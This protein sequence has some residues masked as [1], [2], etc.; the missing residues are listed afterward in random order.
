VPFTYIHYVVGLDSRLQ[1]K[2]FVPSVF[3]ARIASTF[4]TTG[5]STCE[6]AALSLA[7]V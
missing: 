7:D 5:R 2:Q 1:R 6:S 4:H 3:S